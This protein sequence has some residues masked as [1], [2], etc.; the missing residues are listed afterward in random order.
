MSNRNKKHSKKALLLSTA[1]L[2]LIIVIISVIFL[3]VDKQEYVLQ[4]YLPYAETVFWDEPVQ[5]GDTF[6]HEYLHSVELSP[7]REYYKI[8]ENYQMIATE[9]WSKSFGA[10]LPYETKEKLERIDGFFV[11]HEEREI[12]YLNILPSH[13]YPHSFFYREKT[14]DLSSELSGERIRI[15]I[16][17]K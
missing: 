14:V 10:G 7:V 15:Q 1:F 3:P 13:L 16:S 9:S 2:F 11:I 12:E 17:K 8:D 4:I 5:P 6:Y